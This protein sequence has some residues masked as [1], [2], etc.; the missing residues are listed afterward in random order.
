[1]HLQSIPRKALPHGARPLGHAE[2]GH[3]VL[4]H[5]NFNA[6][7]LEFSKGEAA[8]HLDGGERRTLALPGLANPVAEVAKT[9]GGVE[10]IESAAAHQGEGLGVKDAELMT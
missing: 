6:A 7:Q 8:E 10:L 4:G 5:N 2:A 3:V 9:I 1:M